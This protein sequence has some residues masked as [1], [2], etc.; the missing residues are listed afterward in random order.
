M[1]GVTIKRE[2]HRRKRAKRCTRTESPEE[3]NDNSH[4]SRVLC[5]D[6]INGD[7]VMDRGNNAIDIDLNDSLMTSTH[8]IKHITPTQPVDAS[9]ISTLSSPT[10]YTNLSSG[11]S[12]SISELSNNISP[13]V[14]P[15]LSSNVSPDRINHHI[16][17]TSPK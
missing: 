15:K 3:K 16:V 5:G 7:V 1:T 2:S 9:D 8:S 14:S 10:N 17:T 11:C 13:N 12:I 6:F 4:T